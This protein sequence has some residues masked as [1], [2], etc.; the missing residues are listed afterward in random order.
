MLSLIKISSKSY[1]IYYDFIIGLINF[2]NKR[3]QLEKDEINNSEIIIS[4]EHKKQI[5]I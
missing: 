5:I 2:L 3:L 4:D 1:D